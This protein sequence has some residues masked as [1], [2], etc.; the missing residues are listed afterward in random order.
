M[1]KELEANK[2]S[3]LLV[4]RLIETLKRLELAHPMIGFHARHREDNIIKM[5]KYG[6][7]HGPK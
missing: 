1:S 3:A 2:R 7:Q 4:Y 6:K 5:W